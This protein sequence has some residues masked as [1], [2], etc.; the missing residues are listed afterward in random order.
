MSCLSRRVRYFRI[1]PRIPDV[2]PWLYIAFPV[3]VLSVPISGTHRRG[4]RRQ[5]Y[6]RLA[7]RNVVPAIRSGRDTVTFRNSCCSR[8][9]PS[10]PSVGRWDCP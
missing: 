8:T 6:R 4:H 10:V 3:R 7:R 1:L 9:G 2:P 5:R